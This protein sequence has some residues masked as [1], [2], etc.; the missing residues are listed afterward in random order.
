MAETTKG[1]DAWEPRAV[2]KMLDRSRSKC[3]VVLDLSRGAVPPKVVEF[4]LCEEK[5]DWECRVRA[6][7]GSGRLATGWCRNDQSKELRLMSYG[8]T[9]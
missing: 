2:E 9:S 3:P 7:S 1:D 6:A 4:G 5:I 8:V